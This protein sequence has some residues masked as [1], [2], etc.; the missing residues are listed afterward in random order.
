[1][2][3]EY[4]LRA[5]EDSKYNAKH[6]FRYLRKVIFDDSTKI[7]KEI[8]RQLME[9]EKLTM[10]QKTTLERAVSFGS[11]THQHIVN[12]NKKTKLKHI[13]KLKKMIEEG[14]IK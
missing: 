3:Y 11:P 14:K 6:W 2:V 12:L 9:S 13:Q 10:F 5:A 4:I 7:S 8:F 1:M